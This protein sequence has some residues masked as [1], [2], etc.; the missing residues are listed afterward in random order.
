MPF[1][2]RFH[3]K[4]RIIFGVPDPHRKNTDADADPGKNLY[5][6]ADA[7]SCPY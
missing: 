4:N 1:N 5:S 2:F 7:D 3:T 6:D